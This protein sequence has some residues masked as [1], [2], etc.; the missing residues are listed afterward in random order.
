HEKQQE[1]HAPPF[2]PLRAFFGGNRS[3]K[4]T[5]AMCDTIIQAVDRD[6]VPDHLLAYKRWEPPFKCRIMTP[7]FG[8]THEVVLEKI[9][10]WCPRGQ[11]KGGSFDR[12]YDKQ[13]KVLWFKND[14]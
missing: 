8:D 7:D 9:R 14:S 1:F 4:T 5:A 2:P 11:L 3:G 10:E 13:R 6:V 12:G